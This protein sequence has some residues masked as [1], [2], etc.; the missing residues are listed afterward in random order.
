MVFDIL[1]VSASILLGLFQTGSEAQRHPDSIKLYTPGNS[2]W[3]YKDNRKQTR[4]QL[5]IEPRLPPSPPDL[6]SHPYITVIYKKKK[7]KDPSLWVN[8]C[9]ILVDK[10]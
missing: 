4:R 7:K 10:K 3:D 9:L 8:Y 6:I 1:C 2:Y 5:I